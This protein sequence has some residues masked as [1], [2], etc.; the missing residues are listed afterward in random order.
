VYRSGLTLDGP[1]RR[2]LEGLLFGA[3]T[4]EG[5]GCVGM[6]RLDTDAPYP[7]STN[8]ELGDDGGGPGDGADGGADEGG[9]DSAGDSGAVGESVM[10]LDVDVDAVCGEATEPALACA[11][12]G[13]ALRCEQVGVEALACGTWSAEASISTDA[14]T[15]AVTYEQSVSDTGCD[16]VCDWTLQ[17]AI[18]ELAQQPWT[19]SAGGL[20]TTVAAP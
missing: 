6:G 4:L 15:I 3:L 16:S 20:E 19:V 5:V 10:D 13:A 11:W 18:N 1:G 14:G 2:L 8:V 17:W 7:E 9:G 12:D